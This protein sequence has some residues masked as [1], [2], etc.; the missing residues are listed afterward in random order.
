MH[1]SSI[2]NICRFEKRGTPKK[3]LLATYLH[4][5]F[6]MAVETHHT[7]YDAFTA[8]K[9]KSPEQLQAIKI[10]VAQDRLDISSP[11]RPED[12]T[13]FHKELD[14]EFS[15]V[16]N[17]GIKILSSIQDQFDLASN[18]DLYL[19]TTTPEFIQ[20]LPKQIK[21]IISIGTKRDTRFEIFAPPAFLK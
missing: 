21:G 8:L 14:K 20:S 18:V 2:L 19:Y 11:Q 4:N 5:T 16:D 3:G 1:Q 10:I 17:K 12:E 6:K 7:I 15:Q 9:H 13:D